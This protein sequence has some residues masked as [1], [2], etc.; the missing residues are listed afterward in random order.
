MTT[1][2][3]KDKISKHRAEVIERFINIE[4]MINAIISQHYLKKVRKSFMLEV[5]YDEY[6][7]FGLKRRILEKILKKN[8]KYENQIIEQLRRLN[9]IRNYFA[10][11]GQEIITLTDKPL[12][13]KVIHRR[14]IKEE[15]DF[16]SLHDEFMT[17]VGSVEKYLVQVLY[18][19]GGTLITKLP[20]T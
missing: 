13:R 10:H 4:W 20:K 9:N 5:L 18:D 8:S 2:M 11:C 17:K 7:N 16:E 15:L 19:L 6:F 1:K 3:D 14:N 12:K